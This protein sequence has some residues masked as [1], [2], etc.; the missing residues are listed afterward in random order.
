MTIQV[1]IT[2]NAH[3]SP[4]LCRNG[5]HPVRVAFEHEAEVEPGANWTAAMTAALIDA[6]TAATTGIR[7]TTH[8][9]ETIP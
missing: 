3:N 8:G 5:A 9:A 4:E 6:V 7:A 2:I 1:A